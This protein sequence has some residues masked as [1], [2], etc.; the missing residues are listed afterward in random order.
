M[1][2]FT[3]KNFL[4]R[5]KTQPNTVTVHKLDKSVFNFG[6]DIF[7]KSTIMIVFI[8]VNITLSTIVIV[9][10]S[11]RK[12]MIVDKTSQLCVTAKESLS[13]SYSI[14]LWFLKGRITNHVDTIDVNF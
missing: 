8:I 9:K 2:K 13:S 12:F 1:C 6:I 10:I 7:N 11:L 4:R 3:N 5:Y 14:A